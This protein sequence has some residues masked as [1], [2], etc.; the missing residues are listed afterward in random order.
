MQ[1]AWFS[2]W[3]KCLRVISSIVRWRKSPFPWHR[4][5]QA[6]WP[7]VEMLLPYK[8]RVLY[9]SAHGPLRRRGAG[10]W[11]GVH[12]QAPRAP[13][14]LELRRNH[15]PSRFKSCLCPSKFHKITFLPFWTFGRAPMLPNTG[16]N[17]QSHVDS[18]I[19]LKAGGS[20]SFTLT[21]VHMESHRSPTWEHHLQ[22]KCHH[23]YY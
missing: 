10:N 3:N 8:C 20:F 6:L 13:A 12:L 7:C 14:V 22:E 15:S 18:S 11:W 19:H 2:P 9:S 21:S 4:S 16:L 17:S 5:P 1:S 23:C